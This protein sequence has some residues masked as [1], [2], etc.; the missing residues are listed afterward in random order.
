VQ[1]TS[2][3][4]PDTTG[5]ANM[6]YF[7]SSQLFEST[8]ATE[9][10]SETLALLPSPSLLSYYQRPAL[11]DKLKSRTE[12]GWNDSDHLYICPQTLFKFHPDFD[13]VLATILR[14]DKQGKILILEGPIAHFAVLLHQRWQQHIPDVA[15]R[16]IFLPP[17]SSADFINLIAAS[18]LMLDIPSFNGMNTSLEAFA[19]GTPV[20][21]LPGSLQRSR[22]GAGLYQKMGISTCIAKNEEDYIAIAIRLANDKPF[23]ETISN[24][25]LENNHHL[26]A[27]E[28][29]II[30]FSQ[31]FVSCIDKLT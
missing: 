19:V 3:G 12:L 14:Q 15:E 22:H 25:I 1:C 4:H 31:F 18:D 30:A 17:Q 7:I 11:P 21:T 27:D 26:F 16:L 8:Q 29:T 24:E 13:N 6:D 9:H 2:F 5:I 20:V 10:Y 23:R 28:N